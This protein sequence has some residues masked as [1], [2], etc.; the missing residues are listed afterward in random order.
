MKKIIFLLI[1]VIGF[2]NSAFAEVTVNG[3]ASIVF[4]P[5]QSQYDEDGLESYTGFDAIPGGPSIFVAQVSADYSMVGFVLQLATGG[6]GSIK[7]GIPDLG[8]PIPTSDRD[9]LMYNFADAWIGEAASV[10]L[11]P[12]DWVRMDIGRFNYDRLRG[13]VGGSNFDNYVIEAYGEDDIFSRF[14]PG[15]NG[16]LLSLTPLPGLYLGAMISANFLTIPVTTPYEYD[17][18]S[19]E[20]VWTKSLQAAIGYDIDGVGQIRAQ[21]IGGNV[22]LNRRRGGNPNVTSTPTIESA[23]AFTGVQDL[24]IDAGIKIPLDVDHGPKPYQI[25]SYQAALGVKYATKSPFGILGRLDIIFGGKSSR[26]VNL[27]LPLGVDGAIIPITLVQ[28]TTNGFAGKAY[29]VPSYSINDNVKV[30]L[31]L[32]VNYFGEG[33]ENGFTVEGGLG[34]GCGVWAGA[35]FGPNN[36][37]AGFAYSM[38]RPSSRSD[39]WTLTM[40][41]VFELFF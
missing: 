34:F 35:T 33:E 10:W 9:Y 8:P 38:P 16:F 30:G 3:Y 36:I 18:E 39:F 41:I 24:V 13:K 17:F 6:I 29:V 22:Y 19:S 4:V 7:P 32:G 26:E 27:E 15:K 2:S 28:D 21:Y 40:P 37:K 14:Q 23:F 12:F 25:S 31:D 20:D 11:K 5:F 1:A